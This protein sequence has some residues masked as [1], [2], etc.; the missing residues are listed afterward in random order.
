MTLI[1]IIKTSLIGF[2]AL[3][4]MVWIFFYLFLKF[5]RQNNTEKEENFKVVNPQPRVQQRPLLK[6]SPVYVQPVI[7]PSQNLNNHLHRHNHNRDRNFNESRREKAY[8]KPEKF[9]VF[10]N[11][12][13]FGFY[14][15]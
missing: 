3:F 12:Q 15:I 11:K 9:V 5:K 13:Q 14:N 6:Q 2:S 1:E 4:V 10:N 8:A 7:Y